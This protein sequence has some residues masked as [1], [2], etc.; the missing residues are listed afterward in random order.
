MI[1]GI[2]IFLACLTTTIGVGSTI[3][4][5]TVDLSGGKIHFSYMMVFVCFFGMAKA[6]IGVQ[7][8]IR[9]I[10]WIFIAIYPVS[11][12]LMILGGFCKYVPNHGAWK[13][14]VA[15]ATIIGLFEGLMQ[16][17]ESGRLFRWI[18][19]FRYIIVFRLHPLVLH[20]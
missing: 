4:N 6:C 3:A 12:A 11:I 15:M 5:L 16:L 13:G 19:L 10:F 20:G 2:G 1:L 18:L 14:T 9:Y 17:N 8:I 7:G